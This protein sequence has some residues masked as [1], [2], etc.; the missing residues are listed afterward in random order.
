SLILMGDPPRVVI[1]EPS[2]NLVEVRKE[3]NELALSHGGTNLP[4]TFEKIEH[5]LDASSISQK[6]VVFLTDLQAAT[7]RASPES[8]GPVKRS[9]DRMDHHRARWVVIDLGRSGGENRG[10]KDL[11]LAVPLVTSGATSVIRTVLHNYG[12]TTSNGVR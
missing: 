12:S 5:V 11:G 10:V 2:P 6:E 7:G 3:L 1:G 9:L 4:A 8:T